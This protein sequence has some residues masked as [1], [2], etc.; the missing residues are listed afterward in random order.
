MRR[1]VDKVLCALPFEHE[2]FRS[3]GLDAEFVGHPFFDEAAEKPLDA[4]FLAD[5]ADESVNGRRLLAILPG[6]RT[7]EVTA[8]FPIQIR[9]MERLAQRHPTV[10]F[11]VANF[12][13]SQRGLCERML[14]ER[15][16]RLPVTLHIGQTA[17]ILDASEA[18]C[19]VS[20]SVSLEVLAKGLPAVVVYR[21]SRWLYAIGRRVFIQCRFISLP[22]LIAGEPLMPEVIPA[23]PIDQAAD[24]IAAILDEW[25]AN[26][27][28]LAEVRRRIGA[29]RDR[30]VVAGASAE[31]ARQVRSFVLGRASSTGETSR[32]AA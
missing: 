12:R 31:A 30:T 23:E 8:N 26:P 13:E 9:V 22:N 19:M 28:K 27:A 5:L 25:L 29:L 17:E 21:M 1:L 7:H 14:T 32:R 6:S 3:R 11:L 20:G 24:E 10:R 18:T 2:W 15:G 16:G 4:R